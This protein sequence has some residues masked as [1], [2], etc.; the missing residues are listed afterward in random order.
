MTATIMLTPLLDV[1][2]GALQQAR[3]PQLAA[4]P[5]L[6]AI[7]PP[8]VS[9]AGALGGI[10]SSRTT[11]KLEIGVSTSRGRPETPALVDAGIVA[12]LSLV[13]FTLIGAIGWFLGQATNLPNMPAL[14]TLVGLT[15]LSGALLTPITLVAGYYLAVVTYR[16]SLDPDNQG[17]PIITS[18][19][20]LAGVAV[21]IFVA[22]ALATLPP[23]A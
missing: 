16:S 19:M 2:S 17:V 14:S 12:G 5:V 18:V 8:F 3:L 22:T 11:S 13:V 21:L 10:F 7:I 6:L 15:V 4:T 9:Q 20:D 23:T 1:A